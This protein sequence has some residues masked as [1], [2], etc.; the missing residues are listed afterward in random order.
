MGS[1]PA[2]ERSQAATSART[3][4][5]APRTTHG[6]IRTTHHARRT[7]LQAEDPDHASLAR[8]A[9]EVGREIGGRPD[10]GG[11]R[12]AHRPREEKTNPPPS[13]G[14]ENGKDHRLN[15]GPDQNPKPPSALKKKKR[16]TV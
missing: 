1:P 16:R 15:P 6:F 13:R 14:E 9:C 7:V 3:T 4:H 2:F 12:G 5:D 11:V 10:G 8:V